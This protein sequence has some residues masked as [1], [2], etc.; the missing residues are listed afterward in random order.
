MKQLL[1]VQKLVSQF[2]R[3]LGLGGLLMALLWG[4][5]GIA[6]A[7]KKST[8]RSTSV[9]RVQKASNQASKKIR[10]SSKTKSKTSRSVSKKSTQDIILNTDVLEGLSK[11]QPSFNVESYQAPV[12]LASNTRYRKSPVQMN[13]ITLDQNIEDGHTFSGGVSLSQARNMINFKDGNYGESQSASIKVSARLSDNWTLSGATAVNNNPNDTEDKSNG[14]SDPSISI[15]HK[16]TPI[17]DTF[18]GGYSLSAVIPVSEY[19]TQYQNLQ[20]ILGASYRIGFQ[21]DILANGLEIGFG[22]GGNRFFHRYQTDVAGTVL[23]EYSLRESFS[24]SYELGKFSFSF[25]FSHRHGWTY[26]GNVKQIY[27]A[28][29]EVSYSVSKNWGL[30]LGHTNSESWLRPNGQDSNFKL[31]NE[32][33]SIVYVSTA[34]MF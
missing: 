8:T 30:S 26:F 16:S 31:I 32:N 10:T 25:D 17:T 19:T 20:G 5:T 23:N 11:K 14:I 27:E 15:S 22:L 4:N 21:K 7:N 24:A 9:A 12:L 34:V 2:N 29:E 3:G 18:K 1:S 13:S 6:A 33:S 28:S